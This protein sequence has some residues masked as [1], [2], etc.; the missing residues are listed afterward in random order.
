MLLISATTENVISI[1]IAYGIC[2]RMR[3]KNKP[4]IGF[5]V[6]ASRRADSAEAQSDFSAIC[7]KR[8][9]RA[10]ASVLLRI[11]KLKVNTRDPGKPAIFR[12]KFLTKIA[13]PQT[14]RAS[15]FV[16][17]KILAMSWGVVHLVKFDHRASTA[18]VSLYNN[19]LLM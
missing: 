10:R 5:W 7:I 17:P 13:L 6:L 12:T 4:R 9:V 16:S 3:E 2:S 14:D 1:S 8:D 18:I 19:Y 15:A 11:M